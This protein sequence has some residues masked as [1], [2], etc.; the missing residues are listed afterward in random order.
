[1]TGAGSQ[2]DFGNTAA[3]GATQPERDAGMRI[4]VIMP[5]YN[6]AD[7]LARSLPPLLTMKGNGEIAEIIVV[8]DGSTDATATVATEA[9]VRLMHSGGRVGPGGARNTAA[10]VAVGSI[11][12]FV[13]A[14]VV[15]HG[16]AARVLTAAF[17]RSG[18]AAVFGCYDDRPAATNFLSQ[19]KNLVHHYYH[20]R[21]A[22]DADTFWAGCGAVRKEIF[23]GAGGFDAER[24]RH[25]SI[26]DIEFGFRL[27]QRGLRIIL[28]PEVQGTHLKVWRLGNLLHTDIFRRAL[29]W[30]RLIHAR[31]GLPNALNLGIGERLNAAFLAIFLLSAALAATTRMTIGIPIAAL[32]VLGIL[33]WRLFWLFCRIRGPFFAIAA[34]AFHQIYYAYSSVVF[35]WTWLEHRGQKLRRSLDPPA[36]NAPGSV[37]HD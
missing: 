19:Y 4:S 31:S 10:P 18:A 33:N 15:V 26:E 1:M 32:V 21:E 29:P 28:A 3:P 8:D 36:Q 35:V 14:D 27:R 11:L 5:V 34:I 23:L 13:D 9:G 2:M 17:E 12:W 24:F 37:R 25:P 7:V 16:D 30:S 22:G 6:G 20:R